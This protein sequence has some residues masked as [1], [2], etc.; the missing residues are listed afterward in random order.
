MN[1]A[2]RGVRI[3]KKRVA[4]FRL[5][6]RDEGPVAEFARI[7]SPRAGPR[8][9]AN[10]AM[11]LTNNKMN[12]MPALSFDTANAG[13]HRDDSPS[14][15]HCDGFCGYFSFLPSNLF[16]VRLP[17]APLRSLVA[18]LRLCLNPLKKPAYRAL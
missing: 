14:M 18:G 13:W 11:T 12:Y 2:A 9:F 8:I 10:A 17:Q 16:R 5:F 3:L 15:E 1:V 4:E 6:A 7:P